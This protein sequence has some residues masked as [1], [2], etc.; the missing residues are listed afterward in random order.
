MEV[1]ISDDYAVLYGKG[2]RFY[3]GYEETNDKDEWMF[4]VHK[5]NKLVL[6]IPESE[7]GGHQC[8]EKLLYGIGKYLEDRL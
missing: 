5:D 3:F 2:M 6:A 1:G 8:E 7:L 4:T